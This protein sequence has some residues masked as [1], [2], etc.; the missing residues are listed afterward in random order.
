MALVDPDDV[1]PESILGKQYGMKSFDVGRH[2]RS[3]VLAT[4]FLSL[5]FLDWRS[6][7]EKMN[8]TILAPKAKTWE[9]TDFEL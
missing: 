4:L 8:F 6:K 7:V 1:I 2:K 3:E 5:S 9:F